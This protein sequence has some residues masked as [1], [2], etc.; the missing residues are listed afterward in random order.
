MVSNQRPTNTGLTKWREVVDISLFFAILASFGLLVSVGVLLTYQI[1][2]SGRIAQT[3]SEERARLERYA[4][5]LG[6]RINDIVGDL[7]LVGNSEHLQSYLAKS[8]SSDI[9]SLK[10]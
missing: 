2:L 5:I 8:N 4:S 7:R 3:A 1:D 10:S 6:S 9:A